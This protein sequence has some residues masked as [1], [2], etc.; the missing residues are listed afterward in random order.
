MSTIDSPPYPQST[1]SPV[2][3]Y[4]YLTEL[5]DWTSN[6]R[7]WAN[8]RARELN[9][10]EEPF[11][12]ELGLYPAESPDRYLQLSVPDMFMSWQAARAIR[13]KYDQ[14]V[15]NYENEDDWDSDPASFH[16]INIVKSAALLMSLCFLDTEKREA[17]TVDLMKKERKHFLR[18]LK[19]QLSEITDLFDGGSKDDDEI[20]FDALFHP[21]EDDEE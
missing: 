2:K 3:L 14:V 6:H 20:D 21:E 9:A 1:T 16:R 18:L 11:I 4:E 17:K 5:Y 13:E 12:S 7:D 10:P 15:R 19:D 8:M